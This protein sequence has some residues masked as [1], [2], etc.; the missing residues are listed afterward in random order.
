MKAIGNVPEN[1]IFAT[2][3]LVGLYPKLKYMVSKKST[4]FLKK[5]FF[6]RFR[7]FIYIVIIYYFILF[8]YI[9]SYYIITW[10]EKQRVLFE[11]EIGAFNGV[12][13]CDLVG[14][15]MLNE[16]SKKYNKNDCL[17]YQ[18]DGLVVLKNNMGHKQSK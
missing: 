11:V 15:Y 18:D 2:A 13:V 12:E 3:N 16:L 17:L 6:S 4:F 7:C 14:T 9:L 8:H 1:A 10:I 5:N